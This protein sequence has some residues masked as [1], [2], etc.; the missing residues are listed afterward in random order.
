MKRA[1]SGHGAWVHCPGAWR[2]LRSARGQGPGT[3]PNCIGHSLATITVITHAYERFHAFSLRSW[4]RESKYMLADLLD[5]MQRRG[6]KIVV[7]RGIPD[8]PA[9]TEVAILHLDTTITPPEYLAYAR[10]FRHCINL[11][12]GDIS[13][14]RISGALVERGDPWDGPVIV[15]T[16]ANHRGFPEVMLNLRA[17][18]R[19]K[20]APFPAVRMIRS[21]RI[22]EHLSDV[23]ERV[24]ANPRLITEKFIS[25]VD[26][27]GY[28]LRFWVF[29]GTEER[30]T[31]YVSPDR[32]LKGSSVVRSKPVP[33]PAALREM[34]AKLG[35]DYGKFDFVMHDGEPVLLDANKTLGRP[36]HLGEAYVGEVRRLTDGLESLVCRA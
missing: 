4:R 25:E 27:Q 36:V 26:E 2:F 21:Y 31:R 11:G 20:P 14:R 33:V 24:F 12:A 30:C 28:A 9:S 10:R 29:C 34:R 13:K 22:F 35:F 19:G 6:H 1:R 32:I 5:E 8:A 18:M 16:D 17:W 3:A 15:K 7:S 23:P